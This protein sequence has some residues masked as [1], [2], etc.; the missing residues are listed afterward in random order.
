MGHGVGLFVGHWSVTH[1]TILP[2]LKFSPL[3]KSKGVV[4]FPVMAIAPYVGQ[5]QKLEK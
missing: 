4:K 1:S 3:L 5:V 2:N